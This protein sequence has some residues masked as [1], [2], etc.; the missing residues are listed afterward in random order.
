MA[1][2][3]TLGVLLSEAEQPRMAATWTLGG[4]FCYLGC[5]DSG[6]LDIFQKK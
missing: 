5:K 6:F 1:A 3:G 4:F 2:T